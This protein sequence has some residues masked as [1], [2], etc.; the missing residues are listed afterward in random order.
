MTRI[1]MLT[2]AVAGSLMLGACATAPIGPRVAVMPPAGKPFEVFVEDDRECRQWADRLSG[3][4]GAERA[5][6]AAVGSAVLGTAIGAAAGALLGGHEGAGAGAGMGLVMGSAAGAERSAISSYELQRRYD[7]SYQQCMAS[8]GNL[9]ASARGGQ[10]MAPSPASPPPVP[11][12]RR[13]P[14]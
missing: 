7:I 9:P 5:N 1:A 2:A 12:Q 6:E 10:S 8:K 3:A 13:L 14:Y 11:E 4:Q